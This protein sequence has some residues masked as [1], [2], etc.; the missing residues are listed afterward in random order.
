ML[1]ALDISV[2]GNLKNAVELGA[3]GRWDNCKRLRENY[4]NLEEIP[5]SDFS[6]VS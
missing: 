5:Y 2:K 6:D 1:N 3:G 4:K